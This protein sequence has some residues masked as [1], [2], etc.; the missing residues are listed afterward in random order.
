MKK[1]AIYIHGKGGNVSEAEHYKSLLKGYEVIGLDY[2]SETPWDAVGEFRSFFASLDGYDSALLIANSIGAYFAMMAL[3][4]D[5]P[6]NVAAGNLMKIERALFIS[7]VVNMEKLI[8]NMMLWANVSETDLR[9]RGE[10]PTKFGETLSWKYLC[11]VREH[12]IRWNVC[13]RNGVCDNP[14]AVNSVPTDILY[15]FADNVTCPDEIHNFAV[16]SGASLTVMDG[17][18][19]WFHT[20]GQME[21]LDRWI[22][23]LK[24]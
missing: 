17:G 12:P 21:F 16:R 19:H 2:K 9:T 10:I 22:V 18:E 11:Y 24:L 23:G 8:T 5:I 1:V 4:G 14:K 20:S 13:E 7:P 3:G 6:C 15:G